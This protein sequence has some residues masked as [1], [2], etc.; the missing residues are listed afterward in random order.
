MGGLVGPHRVWIDAPVQGEVI[1]EELQ[2]HDTEYRRE[3]LVDDGQR[4]RLGRQRRDLSIVLA[5]ERDDRG[6][7]FPRHPGRVQTALVRRARRRDQEDDIVRV[8][9]SPWPVEE[10]LAVVADGLGVVGLVHLQGR[11]VGR[12]GV[13]P[14]AHEPVLLPASEAAR[15]AVPVFLTEQGGELVRHVLE[16]TAHGLGATDLGRQGGQQRHRARVADRV[17]GRRLLFDRPQRVVGDGQA[18]AAVLAGDHHADAGRSLRL[19]QRLEGIALR[20]AVTDD[21]GSRAM[22]G[23]GPVVLEVERVEG[24]DTVAELAGVTEQ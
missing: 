22:V 15:Q 20:A 23:L 4:D 18:V 6:A 14:A 10:L 11:F 17:G 3:E 2:R 12:R 7:D 5:H 21:D 16:L 8:D 24:A 13:G 19:G 9:A 1:G